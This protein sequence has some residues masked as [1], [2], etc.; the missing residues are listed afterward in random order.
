MK[1]HHHYKFLYLVFVLMLLYINTN[2]KNQHDKV[3]QAEKER[4]A[5]M[6]AGDTFALAGPQ[7]KTK[8]E[9]KTKA[10]VSA[11]IMSFKQFMKHAEPK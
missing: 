11:K 1:N 4:Y 9:K 3:A 5:A 2:A 7:K 6:I 10:P 8:D